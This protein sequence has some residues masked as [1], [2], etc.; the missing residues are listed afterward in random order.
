MLVF[1]KQ[2]IFLLWII[3]DIQTFPSSLTLGF[4]GPTNLPD[5][6]AQVGGHPALFAF[7]LAI[8][9][10]NNRKDILP[11]TKLNFVNNNTNSD[12][13]MGAIDAFWQCAYGNVVGI[14]GEYLSSVSQ[15]KTHKLC[16]IVSK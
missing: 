10:I 4:I 1:Y 14:V 6:N 5:T 3:N 2:I 15:V 11:R 13:G 9:D 7:K 8:R 16:F 12:I